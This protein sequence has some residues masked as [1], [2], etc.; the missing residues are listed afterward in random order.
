MRNLEREWLE[1]RQEVAKS[2]R[3]PF[4]LAGG[5]PRTHVSWR[6]VC[7]LSSEALGNLL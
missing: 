7:C 5:R 1:G 2:Q 3:L 4:L 6:P